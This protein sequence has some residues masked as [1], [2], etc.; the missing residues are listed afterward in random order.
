MGKAQRV[1]GAD[2]E[3]RVAK[4][5]NKVG[6]KKARR[7]LTQYQES[8]G[9]DIEGVEPFIPQCK[10]GKTVNWINAYREAAGSAS[11]TQYPVA[12]V[13][14]DRVGKYVVLSEEDYFEII[15]GYL[16]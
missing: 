6:F 4:L 15:K 14:L 5:Y 1:K 7:N 3:R 10:C 8:D 13:H 9:C 16:A 12:H 2:E 11:E